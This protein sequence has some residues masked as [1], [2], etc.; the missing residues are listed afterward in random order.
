MLKLLPR[1]HPDPAA[2]ADGA[3]ILAVEAKNSLLKAGY[4]QDF[5]PCMARAK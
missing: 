1:V 4:F 2:E 5:F 3:G